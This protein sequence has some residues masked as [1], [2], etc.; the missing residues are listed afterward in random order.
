MLGVIAGYDELDPATVDTSVPD[1]NR[2]FK[3]QTSRLR[4][5]VPRTPFFD[6]LDPE[7]GKALE[8]AIE[9]LRELTATVR[10]TPLSLG[11]VSFDDI[12]AKV[13]PTTHNT[14]PI[15]PKNIK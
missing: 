2:A 11:N 12:F 14:S 7:I 6:G 5:G 13:R 1:Y 10:D 8:A 9:V 15:H 4:L 3:M